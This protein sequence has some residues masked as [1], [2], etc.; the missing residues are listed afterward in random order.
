MKERNTAQ[1]VVSGRRK[2]KE[3]YKERSR[4]RKPR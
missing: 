4:T 1:L 3:G 2:R